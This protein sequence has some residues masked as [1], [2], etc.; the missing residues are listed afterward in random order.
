MPGK[1]S[2]S[3]GVAV[4]CFGTTIVFATEQ[5]TNNLPDPLSLDY[6]LSR[7]DAPHPDLLLQD[8]RIKSI[9]A[10]KQ[11]IEDAGG[12]DAY[13]D[14]SALDTNQVRPQVR[15][16]D[17]LRAGIIL[18]TVLY[19]FGQTNKKLDAIEGQ[20]ASEQFNYLDVRT[21]RR[22]QILT[23]FFNVLLSDLGFSRY[24]EAMATTY[25]SLDRAR[26]RRKLGQETDLKVLELEIEYERVRGLRF[27]SENLQRETRAFLAE[28]LNTPG[29]LP[30]TL[31]MPKMAGL[32]DKLGEVEQFQ[33]MAMRHNYRINALR[34]RLQA[35]EKAVV[36][37][38]ASDSATL[39]GRLQA[40]QYQGRERQAEEVYAELVLEIPLLEPKKD[41]AI[42]TE[43]AKV[44]EARAEL[45]KSE[46]QLRQSI[47]KLWHD[48]EVLQ[49]RRQQMTKLSEFRELSLERSRALYEMEVKADLGNA[50]VELTEA[51]YQVT[52]TDYELA[53]ALYKMKILTGNLN[54][55][56]YDIS[57]PLPVAIPQEQL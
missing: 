4:C 15:R 2:F 51:Q 1:F 33:S 50:M 54:L 13:L 12:L 7:A 46:S 57:S 53:L 3:F 49:V 34:S 44:Y 30:S 40:H 5:I 16:S 10:N 22:L 55:D 9:E 41:S 38:R 52:Q 28:L 32:D 23:A 43:M 39:Y 35:A 29:Q 48:I 11:G 47:L 31:A 27:E 21:Q 45:R 37:A 20:L 36:V 18:S 6:A 24:N 42:A 25:I 56:L 17:H 14:I 8:A 19:D 26:D